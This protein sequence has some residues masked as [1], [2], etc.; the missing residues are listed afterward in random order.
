[1]LAL[2]R[3]SD[4]LRWLLRE[5]STDDEDMIAF[6][7]SLPDSDDDDFQAL[8]D[9]LAAPRTEPRPAPLRSEYQTDKQ[10]VPPAD[11]RRILNIPRATFFAL[12]KRGAFPGPML[13]DGTWVG[14]PRDVLL[15]WAD[16]S[17]LKRIDEAPPSGYAPFERNL[18]RKST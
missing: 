17:E 18:W 5:L 14:W 3:K 1:M 16:T 9:A 6:V 4:L 8:L 10:L 15:Q 13:V 2:P 11:A 12:L 7:A